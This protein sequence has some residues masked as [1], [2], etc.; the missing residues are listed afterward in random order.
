MQVRLSESTKIYKPENFQQL[1]LTWNDS[2]WCVC[3]YRY[4][5]LRWARLIIILIT[6]VCHYHSHFSINP[7]TVSHSLM[8]HV[9]CVDAPPLPRPPGWLLKLWECLCEQG[10]LVIS[11]SNKWNVSHLST[12]IGTWWVASVWLYIVHVNSIRCACVCVCASL[13]LSLSRFV[14]L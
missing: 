7:F 12:L 5:L 6:S 10:V 3:T 9:F 13:S 4:F 8:L 11:A 1:F 2:L 14:F